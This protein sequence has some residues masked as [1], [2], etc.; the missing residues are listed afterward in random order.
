MCK[1][2][3][4]F[5]IPFYPSPFCC[6]AREIT[7]DVLTVSLWCSLRALLALPAQTASQEVT[8]LIVSWDPKLYED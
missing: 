1:L 2:I 8:H 5:F 4:I 7:R 6:K 3:I